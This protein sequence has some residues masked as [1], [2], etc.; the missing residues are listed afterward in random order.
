MPEQSPDPLLG[1][2]YSPPQPRYDFVLRL[3]ADV[4]LA[5]TSGAMAPLSC[6]ASAVLRR[7]V[8]PNAW[9]SCKLLMPSLKGAASSVPDGLR[10]FCAVSVL[11][12]V[13]LRCMAMQSDRARSF[14]YVRC[15][16]VGRPGYRRKCSTFCAP[17]R[18]EPI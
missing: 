8:C 13:H 4:M 2:G 10:F 15:K 14:L 9:R 12:A 3:H 6:E 11:V 16:A 17:S 7:V 5:H 18:R 1:A